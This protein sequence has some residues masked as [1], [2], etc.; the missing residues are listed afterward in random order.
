MNSVLQS[1][2]LRT[3]GESLTVSIGSELP[4]ARIHEYG[5]FAG[6]PG[7]FKKKK[8]GRR[9]YL[10]PRPYLR[11]AINDLQQEVL[12]DLLEQAIQQVQRCRNDFSPRANL[13]G[14][15]LHV[16]RRAL[17]TPAGPFKTVSRRWQDPLQ[18][19]P[20]DRPSLYQV[21]KDELTGPA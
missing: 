10:K 18:I 14:V 15:V 20:A 2:E 5:G 6:R 17:L 19:S 12:P 4:Y 9:P 16:A 21:Q 1:I 8:E 7:P 3:D 13:F 11:P